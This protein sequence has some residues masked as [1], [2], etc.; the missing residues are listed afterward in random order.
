MASLTARLLLVLSL[1]LAASAAS[2]YP[3]VAGDCWKQTA[4]DGCSATAQ[5]AFEV[6]LAAYNA[7]AGGEP[8]A[9]P[10][11]VSSCSSTVGQTWKAT[12]STFPTSTS[13]VSVSNYGPVN[14][15]PNGGT[16]SGSTCT[17][18]QGQTDTGTACEVPSCPAAGT[19][20]G[21]RNVTAGWALSPTPDANDYVSSTPSA[22]TYGEHCVQYGTGMCKGTVDTSSP[23]AVVGCWRSQAPA[24]G[25]GLYRVSCDYT[26]KST[27]T[28]ACTSS[29]SS[30]ADPSSPPPACPTG[31]V[32]TVN[33]KSVC[34]GTIPTSGINFGKPPVG[35]NPRAGTS[36]AATN[37]EREPTAGNG[38]GADA[39]GGPGVTT[40]PDGS[41]G[42][43]SNRTTVS[44][45]TSGTGTTPSL[46]IPTDYQR[47]TTGQLTNTKLQTIIT[48]GLKINET[49]TPNG[50]DALK[51]G[52]DQYTASAMEREGL[53]ETVVAPAN[54][55]TEWTWTLQFP[56]TCTAVSIDMI[57]K[58][59]V[60]DPC[61][62]MDVIHD[63]MSMIWAGATLWVVVSMFGRTLRGT[64]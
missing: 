54:K 4:A 61:E 55:N 56:S 42:T 53:L 36:P 51:T 11:C 15:C 43:G 35:G 9:N 24:D 5:G 20:L 57:Y 1:L 45:G 26:M 46:E 7:G 13:N 64:A 8:Y 37:S 17:C 32:G 40:G 6:W 19:T 25:T 34:L 47:D 31:N 14:T 50:Q 28:T 41:V 59:I 29:S 38:G 39:R 23:N 44:G 12:R 18:A 2:A 22:V 33:G 49:G 30:P 63:L 58:T 10:T 3:A 16:L 27:A 60:L 48:D 62:Y 52:V 21:V